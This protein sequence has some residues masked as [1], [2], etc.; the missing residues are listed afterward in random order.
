MLGVWHYIV[1]NRKENAIGKRTYDVWCPSVG[2]GQRKYTAHMGVG[3]LESLTISYADIV[4]K[5]ETDAD[6]IETVILEE[7]TE[8]P[9]NQTVNN[10]FVFNFNQYGNN[11]TQIGHVENYYGSRKRED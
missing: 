1:V 11:G 9:V 8:Q 10:P 5:V 4:E 2:G 7:A 3:I 6:P